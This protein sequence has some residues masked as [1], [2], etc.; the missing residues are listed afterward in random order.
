MRSQRRVSCCTRPPP[1]TAIELGRLGDKLG[2]R[3]EYPDTK[4]LA[5]AHG[6][7]WSQ[8]FARLL[9]GSAYPYLTSEYP[10]VA[11]DQPSTWYVVSRVPPAAAFRVP[12]SA[13]LCKGVSEKYQRRRDEKLNSVEQG[14]SGLAL[15]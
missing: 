1:T 4:K 13:A 15:N 2:I 5:S 9:M 6:Q 8:G 11:R 10:R 14:I 7:R 12:P 3:V